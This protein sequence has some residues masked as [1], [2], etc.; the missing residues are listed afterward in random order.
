MPRQS[1]VRIVRQSSSF[2]GALKKLTEQ[3]EVSFEMVA[4]QIK[5]SSLFFD[6]R[7]EDKGIIQRY[8]ERTN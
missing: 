6:L 4:L 2:I 8:T 3:Y 1:A 7:E 5:N